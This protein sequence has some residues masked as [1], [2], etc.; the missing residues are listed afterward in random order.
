MLGKGKGG[1]VARN[2]LE[3]R[4]LDNTAAAGRYAIRLDKFLTEAEYLTERLAGLGRLWGA[5]K[6]FHPF[7]AYKEIDW[8]A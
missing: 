2:R 8:D 5:A 7:L 6:F 4:A 3:V 1:T